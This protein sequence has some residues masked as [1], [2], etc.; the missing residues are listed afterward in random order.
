MFFLDLIPET[1][2]SFPLH[3]NSDQTPGHFGLNLLDQNYS[4]IGI[5]KKNN[6]EQIMKITVHL[7]Y[8]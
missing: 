1:L 6:E 2:C 4:D 3:L 8:L 7:L 5:E